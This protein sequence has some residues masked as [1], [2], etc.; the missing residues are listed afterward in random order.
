VVQSQAVDAIRAAQVDRV[1]QHD[2][3]NQSPPSG[4]LKTFRSANDGRQVGCLLIVPTVLGILFEEATFQAAKWA[5]ADRADQHWTQ[6]STTVPVCAKT[7]T[8]KVFVNLS[9]GLA[10]KPWGKNGAH[11]LCRNPERVA[12]GLAMDEPRCNPF[13]VALRPGILCFVPRVS[14]P[15]LG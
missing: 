7:L 8:P 2:S 14:K 3:S 1:I 5:T 4:E 10:L 9:P 6:Q 11:W 13:R 15:T 12:T